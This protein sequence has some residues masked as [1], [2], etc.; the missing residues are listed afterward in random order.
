MPSAI[1]N[2]HPFLALVFTDKASFVQIALSTEKKLCLE[3]NSERPVER[4]VENEVISSM[5]FEAPGS[6]SHWWDINAII[7]SNDFEAA[8]SSGIEEQIP[9]KTIAEYIARPL[10]CSPINTHLEELLQ[11]SFLQEL[12]KACRKEISRFLALEEM[13]KFGTELS[14]FKSRFITSTKDAL[15]SGMNLSPDPLEFGDL[16]DH[17]ILKFRLAL[18]TQFGESTQAVLL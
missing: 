8:D 6:S 17:L 5:T 9:W 10:P 1:L 3:R 16:I 12:E 7:I 2:G 13:R 4:R 14:K 11:P 15:Q 18:M